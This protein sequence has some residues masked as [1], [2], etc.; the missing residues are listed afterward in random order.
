MEKLGVR[1]LLPAAYFFKAHFLLCDA[2]GNV[3]TELEQLFYI[4]LT[5]YMLL[6]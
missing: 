1:S 4:R 2:F 6:K 3:F 5:D